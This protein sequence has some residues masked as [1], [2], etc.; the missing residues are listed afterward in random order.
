MANIKEE[1]DKEMENPLENSGSKTVTKN[2]A[3]SSSKNP[4]GFATR[5]PGV[6][7]ARI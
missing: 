6:R 5:P 7:D 1:K 3:A 2:S 4:E